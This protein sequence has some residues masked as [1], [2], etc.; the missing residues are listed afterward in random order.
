[1]AYTSDNCFLAYPGSNTTVDTM[2]NIYIIQLKNK[3]EWRIS[4]T[5]VSWRT[6]AP[7]TKGDTLYL[8]NIAEE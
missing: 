3:L 7:N 6:R 1:M 2:Y 5:T 4:V 8:Y